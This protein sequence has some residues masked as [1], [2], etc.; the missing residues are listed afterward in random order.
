MKIK[1][2]IEDL[3]IKN[4]L[5][6]RIIIKIIKIYLRLSLVVLWE[7]WDQFIFR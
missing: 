6:K 1:G 3:K 5:K 4:C 7:G 2:E